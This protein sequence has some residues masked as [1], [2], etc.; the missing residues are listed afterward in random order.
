[1]G[2]A[3]TLPSF[4]KIYTNYRV[5]NVQKRCL[6]QAVRVASPT[7]EAGTPAL[8]K[9]KLNLIQTNLKLQCKLL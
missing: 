4:I 3:N 1:M 9:D 2:R 7:G 6:R 5:L 8:L